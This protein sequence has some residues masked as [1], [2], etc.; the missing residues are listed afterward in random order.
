MLIL[1]DENQIILINTE[2]QTTLLRTLFLFYLGIS[3]TLKCILWL[4]RSVLAESYEV[5]DVS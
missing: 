2:M 3:E 5:Q 4:N 1:S